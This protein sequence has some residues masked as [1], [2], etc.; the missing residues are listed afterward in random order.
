MSKKQSEAGASI[1]ENKG[2]RLP[3]PLWS[4]I[5]YSTHIFSVQCNR[6]CISR[7]CTNVVTMTCPLLPV[8][9]YFHSNFQ[10][11]VLRNIKLYSL[12][13]FICRCIMHDTTVHPGNSFFCFWGGDT[14]RR[15]HVK[16]MEYVEVVYPTPRQV[17]DLGAYEQ[18][19]C[20]WGPFVS[21]WSV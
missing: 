8:Y 7:S 10:L 13:L 12:L 11:N 18:S 17:G 16:G 19:V 5:F 4:D 3:A 15:W 6:L 2:C 20:A 14:E 9:W 1:P 21:R